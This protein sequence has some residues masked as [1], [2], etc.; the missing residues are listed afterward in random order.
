MLSI[1][2]R[3]GCCRLL[4]ALGIFAAG[5]AAWSEDEIRVT[6]PPNVVANPFASRETQ[7]EIAPDEP[8]PIRR[9]PTT[10]QNPF[11]RMSAAPPIE[12]PVRRGPVSRWRRPVLPANDSS[13]VRAAILATGPRDDEPQIPWDQLP[14]V[15]DL[16]LLRPPAQPEMN[17][18]DAVPSGEP[19]LLDGSQIV[20]QPNWLAPRTVLGNRTLPPIENPEESGLGEPDPFEPV[21][22]ITGPPVETRGPLIVPPKA[23]QP[24]ANPHTSSTDSGA[25]MAATDEDLMPLVVSD[26]GESSKD[27]LG[28]AQSLAQ[29]AES[30]EDLSSI[31]HFCQRGLAE[32]PPAELAGPLR[33]L[34]AWAYNRRGELLIDTGRQQEAI[35]D[36]QVA[37]SL[38]PDCS[39]AIHNRA[40]TLAQ[41][42]ETAAALR[43]FNRVIELNPG[44]AIAYRN[45]AELLAS[46][47]RIEEALRDY[48]RALDGLPDNAELYRARGSAWHRAGDYEHALADLN[49]AIELAPDADAYTQRGN[50]AAERGEFDKALS[51]F[52][53]ALEID[54]KWAETYRSLAWLH[55]TCADPNYRD[56]Q[57]AI[58]AAQRAAQLSPPND[59]FVLEALAAA[60]ASAGE[61]AEAVRVQQQA[62]TASPGDFAEPLRQRLA[63]YQQGQ[64]FLS[65]A[66]PAVRAASHE[67]RGDEPGAGE[68]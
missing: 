25:Q 24:L 27:W 66:N 52:R 9:G 37:I 62:I 26:F 22:G 33:R 39:L 5:E 30:I 64:P 11:A 16:L 23:L 1:I 3:H 6:S 42:N 2:A 51:D 13:P 35:R 20:R 32:D 18:P 31:V 67:A 38:N 29:T 55:A 60:Y 53:R 49:R 61:F 17:A 68:E 54:A 8:E 21:I 63:L 7:A 10:Y 43:D 34:A 40:V 56:P 12:I 14:P 46:L 59:S 65:E 47:G 44:L 48:T 28:Q 57:Q 50:V 58:S 4:T 19:P 45:R 36:F 15:E 41:Q